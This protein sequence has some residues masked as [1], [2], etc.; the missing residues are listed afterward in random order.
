MHANSDFYLDVFF[1]CNNLI[2]LYNY[3][4][5]CADLSV[6]YIEVQEKGQRS[7]PELYF[8][9]FWQ[10][11]Y[12]KTFSAPDVLQKHFISLLL[13]WEKITILSKTVW[14]GR[15][16][17]LASAGWGFSSTGL[18]QLLLIN[19]TSVSVYLWDSEHRVARHPEPVAQFQHN[20]Q[21][22]FWTHRCKLKSSPYPSLRHFYIFIILVLSSALCTQRAVSKSPQPKPFPHSSYSCTVTCY[23]HVRYVREIP[24]G[25]TK[26]AK[27]GNDC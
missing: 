20:P 23:Q 19:S 14:V 11:I 12:I 9:F 2:R 21:M 10:L 5:P 13:Q 3:L 17:L 8:L 26:L 1:Y 16:F 27:G 18:H 15:L 4:L 22:N 6:E 24:K 7:I 25:Q